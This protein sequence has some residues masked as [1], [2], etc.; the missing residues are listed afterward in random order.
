M[1]AKFRC[2]NAYPSVRREK[3]M[4]KLRKRVNKDTDHR[5]IDMI[6][7]ILLMTGYIN[8]WLELFDGSN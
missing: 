1:N 3:S 4:E 6:E 5:L 7:I 2:K 8:E